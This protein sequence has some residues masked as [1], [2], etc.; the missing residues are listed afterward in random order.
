MI[1]P[2]M[3]IAPSAD[4]KMGYGDMAVRYRFKRLE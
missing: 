4:G 3:K 2:G 1:M